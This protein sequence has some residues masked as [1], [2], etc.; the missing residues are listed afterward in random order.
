MELPE[1]VWW[2]LGITTTCNARDS[3]FTVNTNWLEARNSPGVCCCHC[4][5]PTAT[6]RYGVTATLQH[7]QSRS[8]CPLDRDSRW[9]LKRLLYTA[10]HHSFTL[11]AFV[12]NTISP[13]QSTSRL[14][15]VKCSL[16]SL[17]S[18]LATKIGMPLSLRISLKSLVLALVT[19]N[20][21]VAMPQV[22]PGLG[23]EDITYSVD[24]ITPGRRNNPMKENQAFTHRHSSTLP[25]R[26]FSISWFL[27]SVS[28]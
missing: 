13:F 22:D 14:N 28:L 19:T 9:S 6:A 23:E 10:T 5:S 25:R 2:H 26:L 21:V 12:H 7:S 18:L 15:C 16:F 1:T 17:S 3:S 11:N 20:I 24:F 27:L 8:R 4:H